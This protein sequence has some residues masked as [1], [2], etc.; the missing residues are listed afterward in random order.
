[1]IC[2]ATGGALENAAKL[3]EVPATHAIPLILSSKAVSNLSKARV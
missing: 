1:M 2:S 3:L